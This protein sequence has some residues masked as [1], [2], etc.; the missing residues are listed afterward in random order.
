MGSSHTGVGHGPLEFGFVRCD[1]A[2]RIGFDRWIGLVDGLYRRSDD[3][4]RSAWPATTD[5]RPARRGIPRPDCAASNYSGTHFP[6][7]LARMRSRT[8]GRRKTWSSMVALLSVCKTVGEHRGFWGPSQRTNTG[9]SGSR[10]AIA[11]FRRSEL[12]ILSS[13]PLQVRTRLRLHPKLLRCRG[14]DARLHVM[15]HSWSCRPKLVIARRRTRTRL[16]RSSSS[17]TRV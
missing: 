17:K 14:T 15:S 12:H 5:S 6:R 7:G 8:R 11:A 2:N 16:R 9:K 1:F 13:Q 3:G 4:D 10:A